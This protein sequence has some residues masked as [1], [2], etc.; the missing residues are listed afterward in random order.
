ML[1][2]GLGS[3]LPKHKGV[4]AVPQLLRAVG[5]HLELLL[6]VLGSLPQVRSGSLFQLC[7]HP[8]SGHWNHPVVPY[9]WIWGQ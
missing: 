6:W 2:A 8:V 1:S 4:G 7:F 3:C 5:Q 9:P